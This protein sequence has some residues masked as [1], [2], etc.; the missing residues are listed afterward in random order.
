MLIAR[1]AEGRRRWGGSSTALPRNYTNNNNNNNNN[2][3]NNN[4]NNN[5]SNISFEK[6]E[7]GKGG[8]AKWGMVTV[9][10]RSTCVRNAHSSL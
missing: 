3:S 2:S 8:W 1:S 4:N 5:N 9:T 6:K 7:T 10:R